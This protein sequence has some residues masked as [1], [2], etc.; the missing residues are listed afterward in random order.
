LLSADRDCEQMQKGT[1]TLYFDESAILYNFTVWIEP[2][3]SRADDMQAMKMWKMYLSR[4]D[5]HSAW[6][7]VAF[8]RYQSIASAEINRS[9]PPRRS[10][11][12]PR[13]LIAP[14]FL[15]RSTKTRS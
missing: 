10:S 12:L 9:L 7:P 3:K 4:E 15:Y 6:W 1:A 13:L 11:V 5:P 14:S 8:K 2:G